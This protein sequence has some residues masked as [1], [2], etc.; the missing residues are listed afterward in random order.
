MKETLVQLVFWLFGAFVVYATA[1]TVRWHWRRRRYGCSRCAY[2]RRIRTRSGDRILC[3]ASC[4]NNSGKV[5]GAWFYA[6][7]KEEYDD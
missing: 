1:F 5:C 2:R 6:E 4:G 7:P 3:T